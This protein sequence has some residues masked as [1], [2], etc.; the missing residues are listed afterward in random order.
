MSLVVKM[1]VRRDVVAELFLIFVVTDVTQ[2]IEKKVRKV[3]QNKI[4]LLRN[5]F[6]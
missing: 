6:V 3:W 4:T 2:T 1:N 5:A